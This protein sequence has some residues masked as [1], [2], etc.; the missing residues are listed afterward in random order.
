MEQLHIL[1]KGTEDKRITKNT[2]KVA[3]TIGLKGFVRDLPDGETEIFA[4]GNR[5]QLHKLVD[6]AKSNSDKHN[7]ILSTILPY[8]GTYRHFDIRQ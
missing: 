3:N 5:E 7:C 1:L 4:E 8:Q 2:C 6:W